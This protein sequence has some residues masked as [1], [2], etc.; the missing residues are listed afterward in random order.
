MNEYLIISLPDEQVMLTIFVNELDAAMRFILDQ[1]VRD[2]NTK[3]CFVIICNEIRLKSRGWGY[4][5]I[6]D[7]P[8]KKIL[9]TDYLSEPVL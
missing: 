6:P 2:D 3:T 7:R 8:T 1:A 9:Y 5:W 4:G